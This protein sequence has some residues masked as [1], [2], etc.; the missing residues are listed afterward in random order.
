MK[1]FTYR[2]NAILLLGDDCQWSGTY[3]HYYYKQKDI[4]AMVGSYPLINFNYGYKTSAK[5]YYVSSENNCKKEVINLVFTFLKK[6][7]K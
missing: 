1:I 6:D 5:P 7:D 2:T 3:G 4:V